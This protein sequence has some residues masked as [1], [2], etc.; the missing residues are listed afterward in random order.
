MSSNIIV[1]LIKK[2]KETKYLN[3]F[4]GC[5]TPLAGVC[6]LCGLPHFSTANCWPGQRLSRGQRRLL[7]QA[8]AELQAGPAQL[9]QQGQEV[10]RHVQHERRVPEEDRPTGEKLFC[11]DGHLQKVQNHF[12]RSLQGPGR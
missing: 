8:L 12:Q 11:L 9:L 1:P 6:P 4:S 5:S 10:G 7:D 2:H 3:S